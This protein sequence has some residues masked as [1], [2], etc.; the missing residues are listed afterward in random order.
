MI[1][2]NGGEHVFVLDTTERTYYDEAR[3]RKGTTSPTVDTLTVRD[4]FVLSGVSNIRVDVRPSPRPQSPVLAELPDCQ[5]VTVTFSYELKASIKVAP[6]TVPGWVKGVGEY[7]LSGSPVIG[8][9]PFGH[10]GGIVS[11]IAEVDALIAE[12]LGPFKGTPV[13]SALTV[14]RQIEGGAEVS[15]AKTLDIS[16]FRSAE[17]SADRFAVPEGF[18]YQEP[19]ITP[20]VRQEE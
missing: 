5:P 3:R 13:H 17:V 10:A 15:Q 11:G 20:P 9:L 19:V 8:T 12:K 1:W 4:P 7:C 14:T 6:V 16:E 18:R 2:K